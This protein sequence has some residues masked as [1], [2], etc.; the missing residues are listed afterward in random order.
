MADPDYEFFRCPISREVGRAMARAGELGIKGHR[1]VLHYI[2]DR[3]QEKASYGE[4]RFRDQFREAST[5]LRTLGQ[6]ET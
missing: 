6:W 1:S 2:A 5:L 3:L 4:D